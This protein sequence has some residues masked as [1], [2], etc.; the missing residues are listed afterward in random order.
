MTADAAALTGAKAA[1]ISPAAMPANAAMAKGDERVIVNYSERTYP[2]VR[3]K[4]GRRYASGND[5]FDRGRHPRMRLGRPQHDAG[6]AKHE[7]DEEI[8]EN[9][10]TH[11]V[12]H[13]FDP[14]SGPERLAMRQRPILTA[15]G[16]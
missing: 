16:Q 3:P 13:D 15:G 12:G 5:P 10:R 1:A 14:D 11:E 6:D 8:A 4:M 9:I 2:P 7:A